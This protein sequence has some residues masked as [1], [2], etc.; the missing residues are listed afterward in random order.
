[1]TKPRTPPPGLI[2]LPPHP[3]PCGYFEERT[4]DFEHYWGF[5]LDDE[6]LSVLLENGYRYFGSYFFRPNAGC[7]GAC[8]PIRIPA[9]DFHASKS[10]RRTWRKAQQAG[11]EVTVGPPVYASEKFA[12]YREHKKRFGQPSHDSEDD[13]RQTFYANA[14]RL[15]EYCYYVGGRLAGAGFVTQ[16][17]R[18]ASSMYF[19]YGAVGQELGLGTFSALYELETCRQLGIPHLYLGYFIGANRWMQYKASF[20]PCEVFVAGEWRTLRG[21]DG[22]WNLDP[23]ALDCR[24]G[25]PPWGRQDSL[26]PDASYDDER[27]SGDAPEGL[28]HP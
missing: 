2:P 15:R 7:C 8:V 24:F 14:F 6:E 3:H 21:V 23:A 19:F 18:V 16:T 17:R 12:L 1:M 22:A 11:V 28:I 10:Q 13:F 26:A 20:R 25:P 4:A 5:H 9:A 27:S